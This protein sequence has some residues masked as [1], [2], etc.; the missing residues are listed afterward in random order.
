MPHPTAD[1]ED[2]D[3]GHQQVGRIGMPERME[4]TGTGIGFP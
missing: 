3:A 2:F 4:R 1:H